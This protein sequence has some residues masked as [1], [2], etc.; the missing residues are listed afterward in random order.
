MLQRPIVVIALEK[1][2]NIQPIHLRGVYLPV[3]ARGRLGR[4]RARRQQ[5]QEATKRRLFGV[6]NTVKVHVEVL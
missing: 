1:L 3:L 5:Q 2:Q 6:R 4:G